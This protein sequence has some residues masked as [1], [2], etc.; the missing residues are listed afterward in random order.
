MQIK[1]LYTFLSCFGFAACVSTDFIEDPVAFMPAR[2]EITP[3]SAALEVGKTLGLSA[4]YYDNQGNKVASTVFEWQSSDANIAAVDAN[5]LASGIMPGQVRIQ[6]HANNITSDPALLTVVVDPTQVAKVI[7]Q[8]DSATLNIGQTVQF[9]AS[10]LNLKDEA[11]SGKAF[12]W[13]SSN[14][15]MRN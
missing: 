12:S 11:V 5:G 3:E 7:V 10:A 13:R 2:I 1:I 4:S 9:S 8:P 6:A 14:T 15:A